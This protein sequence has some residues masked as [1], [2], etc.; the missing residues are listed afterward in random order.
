ME[1]ELAELDFKFST[2]RESLEGLSSR[3]S[4]FPNTGI[5]KEQFKNAIKTCVD[6]M[7]EIEKY[8]SP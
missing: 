7:H 4:I 3:L 8:L 6:D 1:K 5:T 2:L